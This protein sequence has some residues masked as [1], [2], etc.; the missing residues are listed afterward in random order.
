MITSYT[1]DVV[2]AANTHT[3]LR[4]Y[5]LLKIANHLVKKQKTENYKDDG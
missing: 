3:N 4:K 5:I 2:G 1:S